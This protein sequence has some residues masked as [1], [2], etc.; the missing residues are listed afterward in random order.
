MFYL[1]KDNSKRFYYL[2]NLLKYK[3]NFNLFIK[4]IIKDFL[5]KMLHYLLKDELN[6]NIIKILIKESA[7]RFY[8]LFILL[9]YYYLSILK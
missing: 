3:L 5:Y 9:K 4:I 6:F 2:F 1:I 7:K 8:Y